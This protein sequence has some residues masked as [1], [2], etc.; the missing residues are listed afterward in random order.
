MSKVKRTNTFI[1]NPATYAR[2]AVGTIGFLQR[3]SGSLP[4]SAMV[5]MVTDLLLYLVTS[6]FIR[7]NF[8][9]IAFYV[10]SD[11]YTTVHANC[12]V[13]RSALL[14]FIFHPQDNKHTF[15]L[16]YVTNFSLF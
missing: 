13:M 1:P 16:R 14:D 5:T 12:T 7:I 4:D 6:V 15:K 10:W 3:T 11:I 8:K 9:N 2:S